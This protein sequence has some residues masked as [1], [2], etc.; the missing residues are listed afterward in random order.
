MDYVFWTV[1]I[2]FIR[3]YCG[4]WAFLPGKSGEYVCIFRNR[5]F[6][7]G[8]E[9]IRWRF[10]IPETGYRD[11]FAEYSGFSGKIEINKRFSRFF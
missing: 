6:C 9:S 10:I 1:P 2:S 3:L 4:Y 7:V 5:R 11:I 8:N